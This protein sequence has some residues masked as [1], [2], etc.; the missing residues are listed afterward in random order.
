MKFSILLTAIV[1]TAAA[2]FGWQDIARMDAARQRQQELEKEAVSLGIPTNLPDGV[3]HRSQRRDATDVKALAAELLAADVRDSAALATAGRGVRMLDRAGMKTLVAEFLSS[4][5]HDDEARGKLVIALME[6]PLSDKP[7][8]AVALFD[9]FMDA[10]GKV[11]EREATIL[12]PTLLEKWA[13][14]DAAGTLSWLQDRWSRYPQVIKQ[15]AKGKVLTAV[16]AVDPERAFRVIGQ[17]GVVEP[18]DGV[19]A[20]MRGGA[21]GEQ[22]LSVLTALRGY[23][24]GISDAEL[25]KEYAKVAMGAFASSVVS[26]GEASARQWIASAGFT[27]AELDAF[28]AGIAREPVRPEDVPGW[29]GC[30]TAAGGESVPR[31]PLHDLVER[32]TRDDYRAAGK[33][34][35]IAPEGPA[36][37]VAVRSYAGTVAKYD[38]ATAEQ[39]ALTLPAGEE[40][41]ATLSAIHQQWPEADAAGKAEFAERHGIR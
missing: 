5:S 32:W 18:Q 4:S 20:V 16:A 8:T 21:T 1:L 38:P 30:L 12:F 10:G 24:A 39:W 2:W 27:P 7:E 25:Q 3:A 35:A 37:Q 40:R 41:A 17:V 11:D 31:K 15:G 33:W 29:I 26:G 36:K 23:L 34:L 13:V 6:G 22:R 28:A 9:L 19:R 14:S